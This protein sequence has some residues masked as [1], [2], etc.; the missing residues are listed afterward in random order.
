MSNIVTLKEIC[1]E[2]SDGLHKAPNF[3]PNGEYIFVNA[4]NLDNG[5][6]IY[7]ND[8]KRADKSEYEKYKIEL[9]ENTILYSIDG[10]IGKIAKYRNEKVI[11][12][13]GACYLRVKPEV[14]ADYIYYLLQSP[15]FSGYINTMSTGSTIHH[16]S[17]AT[18]RNYEFQIP[19]REEQDAIAY[20]LSNIDK[21]I[22]NNKRI[23]QKLEAMA[24]TLYDYWFVQFDFPDAN[25]RPYKT[26][27]G[28]M[29]WNET[30]SR[31]IPAGWEVSKLSQYI[32]SSRGISYSTKTLGDDGIPMVNLASF[33]PY[34][35]YKESG[36][37][38]YV[39][40]YTSEDIVKPY[41]LIMCN[42]QQTAIK[43]ETDIIGHAFLMPD[44]YEGDVVSSHHM[45][46]IHVDNESLKYY[47]AR[48]FNTNYFHKYISGH[49]NGTNILGLL[50]SG[51]E[52]Y[53]DVIPK[54]SVLDAFAIRMKSIEQEKSRVI[55]E[56]DKLISLRQFMLPMLMN[57]QVT[58]RQ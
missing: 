16:I 57:G 53:T 51:V 46:H 45:T 27:G 37:K 38:R 3:T 47:L 25:G 35:T 8:G 40:K 48:L 19:K 13:K 28:K 14:N 2:L 5:Y 17:L 54:Q 4:N 9:D 56:N 52:D 58:F 49:T 36:I 50:F 22:N 43:F 20:F 21:K 33:G 39:G 23:Q 10:T 41:E 30:L 18:M 34:G 29:E 26:S 7:P 31:A 11:L 55:K 6:I 32:S 42:T 1:I 24:K 12:G 15:H 44:I